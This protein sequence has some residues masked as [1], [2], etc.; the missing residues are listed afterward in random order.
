MILPALMD[1]FR[2]AMVQD[3]QERSEDVQNKGV[4][5]NQ[6]CEEHALIQWIVLVLCQQ[7]AL[8]SFNEFLARSNGA[9]YAWYS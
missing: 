6:S 4:R 8:T 5:G 2:A 9:K 3:R 7:L 1:S